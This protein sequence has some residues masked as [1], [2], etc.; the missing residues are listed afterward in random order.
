MILKCK[1]FTQQS[2]DAKQSSGGDTGAK[3]ERNPANENGEVG[4]QVSLQNVPTGPAT[5]Q[6]TDCQFVPWVSW[7]LLI[8]N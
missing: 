3:I 6:K 5:E 7:I 1:K 2:V 4:G 8:R